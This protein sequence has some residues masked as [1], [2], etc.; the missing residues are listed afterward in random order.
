MLQTSQMSSLMIKRIPA[1]DRCC[2]LSTTNRNEI[3]KLVLFLDMIYPPL[4]GVQLASISAHASPAN[5]QPQRMISFKRNLFYKFKR[6][7]V[8]KDKRYGSRQVKTPVEGGV[9]SPTE[10]KLLPLARA[11]SQAVSV[12]CLCQ[13]KNMFNRILNYPSPLLVFLTNILPNRTCTYL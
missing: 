10:T 4:A 1:L 12:A 5:Y 8:L 13:T 7:C 9:S 2:H 11:C 6:M 3:R